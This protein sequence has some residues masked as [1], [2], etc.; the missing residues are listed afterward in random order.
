[1]T[2]V[3]NN[4]A[5]NV[6]GVCGILCIWDSNS[7]CRSS[8]TRSDY[9]VIICGVW[10]KSG[11]DLLIVVVYAPQEA[12]EKRILW[13]YL[14]H[15]SEQWEGEIVMMGDFNEVR[16]KADRF[17]SKFNAHDT[18]I[19][20][21]FIY[22]AGLDEVPLGGSVYTW[23]HNSASKMNGFDKLVR[24]SWNDAP[25]HKRNAIR[26]LM[27][28]LKFIKHRIQSWLSSNRCRFDTPPGNRARIDICFPNSL[29]ND[30][31][32]ELESMVT[33]EEINMCKSK[34]MGVNVEDGKVTNAASKLG[35]LILK[36]PF[37]YLGTKVGDNIS[38]KEAWKEVVDKVVLRLSRWKIKTLSIGVD[39]LMVIILKV[40]ELLR[41]VRSGVEEAQFNSLLEILQ[42]TTLAPC[43]DRYRWTLESDG[44]F[45]VAS[46]RLEMAPA[47]PE[48][49][50]TSLENNKE[51]TSKPIDNPFHK[52]LG[53]V[54]SSFYVSNFPESTNA[55]ELWNT[56]LPFGRLADAYIPNRRSKGG[57]RFGFIRFFGVSDAQNFLQSLSNIWIGSFHLFITFAK[58]Q[59]QN[60]NGNNSKPYV[61]NHKHQT[62]TNPVKPKTQPTFTNT[63]LGNPSFAS[64]VHGSS[65]S[66]KLKEVESMSN[67]YSICRNEG[68]DNLKIHHVGGLWIWIQFPSINSRTA[69][70]DNESVKSLAQ[71]FKT[72]TP[73]FTV[74]EC[75]VWIEMS[76]DEREESKDD[77][78]EDVNSADGIDDLLND[79]NENKGHNDGIPDNI[80]D[81]NKEKCGDQNMENNSFPQQTSK[82]SNSNEFSRPSGFKNFK[83]DSSSSSKCSTSFVK[84]KKKDIKGFSLINEM[85]RII[86]VGDSLGYD[87]RDCRKSLKK[88]IDG[89]QESKMTKLELFRLKS[90]WGNYAF[91]YACSMARGRSGQWKI[92]AGDYFMI[93]IYG[94]QDS[95]DKDMLWRRIGDFMHHNNG[96]LVLFG[97]FNEVRFNY[98]CLGSTFSQAQA[99]SFNNFITNNDLNELPM[100]SRLFTWM[101]KA[102]TKLSKLDRFLLSENVTK[103]LPDAQVTALD[104]FI[105]SEW[106]S[107]GH[108]LSHEKLKGLKANIKVCFRDTK[109]IERHHKE[110]DSLDMHQ[111]SRIKW[112]IEGD[113]NFKFFHGEK[114]ELHDSTIDFH[115]MTFPTALDLN[116]QLLIQKDITIEEIKIAVWN[117]GNDKAPGPDGFTFGFIKHYW[118]IV[119]HDIMEF[120]IRFFESKKIPTGSNSSF[121]TLI[122][123][124][125]INACLVS[126]R[127]S[128]LINESPTSEFSVKRGLRQGDP[129]TLLL[130]INFIDGLHLSLKEACH[131]GLIHGIKIGS[132]NITLSH[133]FY[134]DD[135]VI[136]SEWNNLDMENII[137]IL[138]VF[139]LASNLKINI[140]KYNVYG[141]GVSDIEILSMA[142]NIGRSSG[143]FPFVYRG[144]P[145]RANMNLSTNWKNLIDRLFRLE[146]DKDC[147]ISDR[148]I[149]N[150]WSWNWSR[151]FLGT[152]NAAYLSD[153]INEITTL[154]LSLDP[155]VCYWS[156]A[157]DGM[158]SV[159]STRH[160]ID[161]HSL[162]ALD[163][164]TQWDKCIPRKVNIFMWRF[165]LD[166]LPHRLN[167][168]SRGIDI[169]SIGCPLC[170]ANVESSNHVFFDCDNAKAIWNLVRNLCD[171]AFPTCA[172]FDQ[173]MVWFDSWQAFK[174]RKRRL[175]I[176]FA[177]TLWWLWRLTQWDKCIPRK[178][179]IFM[180]RFMLDRLPH[181]LNISS[182]GID[183]PS[184]GCPLCSANVESSNHVFF[185]C[186]NAKAIWN[187][188]RNL[189]DLAFPTCASFDQWMVWFD[190]WQA[191][192]ERKRRLYI[193]F[194]ATLWWLWRFRNNI[195]FG[196]HPPK[197]SVIY[198]NIRCFTFSWLHHRGRL[199]GSWSDWLKSPLLVSSNTPRDGLLRF[200]LVPGGF[201]VCIFYAFF[202]FLSRLVWDGI[203]ITLGVKTDGSASV[204]GG[205]SLVFTRVFSPLLPSSQLKCSSL[206][207]FV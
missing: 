12:K 144:L 57:K 190:S 116:D 140:H 43:E 120:V 174:E 137:R 9:F 20:N 185:D 167:I 186:D 73:S 21:S 15:V 113:E 106:N 45:S 160:I 141:V 151:P 66:V 79:L 18:E 56:F 138:H 124:A 189:C 159:S 58:F 59:M 175:Y 35:C 179:N 68:F 183:I 203:K 205:F 117:C 111:K 112:D 19:F 156:I 40:K 154:E 34:I 61:P 109:A 62:N 83:K 2:M 41:I 55:K 39:F 8:V 23:C 69:F 42:V 134:A 169:P 145:I 33:K 53:K 202:L 161:T 100:G 80:S 110:L 36:T 192:K 147:F 4:F 152:L 180:W 91:D 204:G 5:R 1:M 76:E 146:H 94:P 30:Q 103:A 48:A 153:M 177:A 27:C 184:I 3:G 60:L 196:N 29:S 104:N 74:D 182:R 54:A 118:E 99:D 198:D 170:S 136:T 86:E 105:S 135:V 166:R 98:E 50:H 133:V 95:A 123:K 93:N 157:N 92:L 81:P 22:N 200:L 194:A 178:V 28:K 121:I 71:T 10:L 31:R 176:I 115:C 87:V 128:I 108:L 13:D 130:F 131:S 7:F 97:D 155:D 195:I 201:F 96:A 6:K 126:S 129:L 85:T 38:R 148:F 44:N 149:D 47:A 101:N 46:I 206:L 181:R 82:E 75:L 65:S 162:P 14:T 150:Q 25:G 88:M 158:F 89:I 119:K 127:T 67:M 70:Q 197:R 26:N 165:M 102:G 77:Q 188:V 193:I 172:S 72:V 171:L 191:S 52:E 163:R 168:S 24:E 90:M 78:S 64:I 32:H 63:P 164:L 207:C 143:V 107:F 187:L 16:H 37:T 84:F 49:R 139:Y 17:G 125:W 132:S 114:F 51:N 199:V 173:W 142:N 122:P 11:I